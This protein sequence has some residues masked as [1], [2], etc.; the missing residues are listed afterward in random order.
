MLWSFVDYSLLAAFECSSYPNTSALVCGLLKSKGWTCWLNCLIMQRM[1]ALWLSSKITELAFIHNKAQGVA[2]TQEEHCKLCIFVY[3]KIQPKPSV[4]YLCISIYDSDLFSV[5]LVHFIKICLCVKK[6]IFLY[7]ML[8]SE[9][10]MFG[11]S[12]N[13]PYRLYLP[14]YSFNMVQNYKYWKI[15]TSSDILNIDNRVEF[16]LFFFL[17]LRMFYLGMLMSVSVCWYSILMLI[18][19]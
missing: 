18:E 7:L 14:I 17:V 16:L 9:Y 1:H 10:I 8:I 4:Y 3:P 11:R 5:S 12:E 19:E 15:R 6:R 2:A 13:D